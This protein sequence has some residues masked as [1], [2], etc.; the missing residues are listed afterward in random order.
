VL[1]SSQLKRGDVRLYVYE[2][3]I[4]SKLGQIK[5]NCINELKPNKIVD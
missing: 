4:N 2:S 1:W 5:I 3:S